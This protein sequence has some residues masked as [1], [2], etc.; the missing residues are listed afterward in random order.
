[1]S[2]KKLNPAMLSLVLMLLL[3]ITTVDPVAGEPLPIKHIVIIMQEN[4]SFDEYFGTYPN[5]NGIPSNMRLTTSPGGNQYVEPYLETN[6]NPRGG[7]HSWEAAHEDW[8]NGK[9]DGFVWTSG[10]NAMGYYDYHM[11][12]Y[13]WTYASNYVLF[14]NFFEPVLSYSLPAHLYLIAAQSGG[15]VT[16]AAPSVFDFKTIMEE[17]KPSGISWKYYVGTNIPGRFSLSAMY[18]D[19]DP[20]DNWVL[21]NIWLNRTDNSADGGPIGAEGIDAQARTPNYGLWNPLPHMAGIMN[22]PELLSQD[23]PGYEFYDDVQSGNLPQVSWIIPAESVSEHPNAG[24]QAGQKYVVTLVN[25]IM[26]SQYWKDTTIFITWDDWGGFYDH[27]PPPQVDKYGLGFRVPALLISP[28]AKQSYISHV[29]YDFSSFLVFIE[30]QFGLRP[31]TNRDANANSFNGE[32]DFSQHPRQPLILN[33]NNPP[34]WSTSTVT[35]FTST[36]LPSEI[37]TTPL[38]TVAG[39]VIALVVVSALIVIG[40]V[41]VRKR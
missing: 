35:T 8:D 5:V 31:L 28:Y 41:S 38:W 37:P 16:G 32:F 19:P 11:L 22:D 9:M 26:Q 2:F 10:R 14:D 15:Y 7:P 4:R 39:S 24:P 12:P 18:E 25:T 1:M 23:V 30:D 40:Y 20:T 36:T 3:V 27:V 17:L 34:Q 33:P 13:Y 6:P 29:Q 21:G